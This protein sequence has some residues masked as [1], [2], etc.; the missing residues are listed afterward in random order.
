MLVTVPLDAAELTADQLWAFGP[1]AIE[2]Q[3]TAEGTILL[4]GFDD[5]AVATAA[6]AAVDG[7]TAVMAPGSSPARVVPVDD[8]GLD[9]WRRWAR[10]EAAPPFVIVPAWL[11]DPA[12]PAG[13]APDATLRVLRID[14]GRTFGSGSHATTR[15]VLSRLGELV[16]P[17]MSVLDVGCGSGVLAVGAALLGAGV[18]DAIDIDGDAP[19]ATAD[20][21]ARNDVSDR[22]HASTT[23]LGDVAATGRRYDVVAANLLAPVVVDLAGDLARVVAAGGALV[24][25]GLLEDRWQAATDTLPGLAVENVAAADGWV[26]VTLRPS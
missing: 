25:S 1:A 17:G 2:E 5:Q 14:P 4:A 6:A 22:V 9:G 20:N 24:V 11:A 23:P 16:Q 12:G 18:V 21:A 26:A 8:D 10:E 13:P 7:L 15:L 19:Q 3:E